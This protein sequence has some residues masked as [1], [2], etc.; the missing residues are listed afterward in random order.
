MF[1]LPQ[2]VS[3]TLMLLL[4]SGCSR[5]PARTQAPSWRPSR[6]A[7]AVIDKLDANENR[8][9]EG[10]ELAA[11]PGLA[12]G[13]RFIDANSDKRLSREE[14]E[15]RFE[16]YRDMRIGLMPKMFRITYNGR[17]LTGADV[18]FVPEFFLEDVLEPAHGTTDAMGVVQPGIENE[19]LAAMRVG[20]YRVEVRSRQ[21]QLPSRFNTA[22]TLGVEIP[23]VVDDPSSAGTIEIAL[24]DRK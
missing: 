18:R 9:L 14:L 10:E 15:D 12:A 1:S 5:G 2:C 3:G 24:G 6:F 8:A 17:P 21:R 22:T 20:Y 23:P 19:K 11:A 7:D 13:A 16:L 4:V